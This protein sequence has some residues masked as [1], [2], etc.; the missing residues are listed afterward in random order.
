MRVPQ[1]GCVAFA[2]VFVLAVGS[3][4]GVAGVAFTLDNATGQ[5]LGNPPFTLGF[6]FE[7]NQSITVTALGLFDSGQ[8]GFGESHAVG[9]WDS[10][11]NLLASGTISSGTAG[12]LT[13]Q[14][15]YVNVA[16]VVLALGQQF[17]VG[18]LFTNA[19]AADPLLFPG[20]A[21]NFATDPAIDFLRSSFATG[22][23]LA[24][25]TLSASDDPAYFGPN[26]Q[27]QAAPEP[28]TLFGGVVGLT[29][30]AGRQWRRRRPAA[31]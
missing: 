27:F 11:G 22:G 10:V 18:A 6:T 15:R 17:T 31:I 30:L 25:P 19:N 4:P 13:N 29:W 1:A 23:T 14:F 3:V 12:P 21:T 26:F 28:S 2:V 9:L 20:D 5:T 7:T 8:D 16:P 24:N